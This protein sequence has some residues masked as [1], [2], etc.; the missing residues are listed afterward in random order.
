MTNSNYII[1]I[2]TVALVCLLTS[3]MSEPKYETSEGENL[4][5]SD[6]LELMIYDVHLADAIITSKIMKTKDNELSDSLIYLSVFEKHHYTRQQ[7]EQTI[8]YYSHNHLDSLNNI[9]ER[10]IKRFS[11]EQGNIYK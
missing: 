4:I 1:L 3:C 8:L 2:L 6:S 10:V 7:F 11:V 9:Y 5:P